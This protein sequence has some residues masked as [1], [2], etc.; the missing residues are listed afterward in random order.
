MPVLGLSIPE[1]AEAPMPTALSKHLKV[2]RARKGK[3]QRFTAL[4]RQPELVVQWFSEILT[5]LSLPFGVES[6]DLDS[7]IVDS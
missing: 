7:T 2:M 1:L 5:L 4:Q 3:S 6:R